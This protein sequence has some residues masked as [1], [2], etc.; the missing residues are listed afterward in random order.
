MFKTIRAFTAILLAAIL[1]A[2][3]TQPASAEVPDNLTFAE[4][5][6]SPLGKELA[7]LETA[8]QQ[9]FQSTAALEVVTTT[10]AEFMEQF[11]EER[12]ELLLGV[13]SASAR[14]FQVTLQ[15]E[16]MS[17]EM[18]MVNGKYFVALPPASEL[19][20]LKNYDAALSR[21]KKTN[22]VWML[23]DD[24]SFEISTPELNKSTIYN[25]MSGLGQIGADTISLKFGALAKSKSPDNAELV[26]YK[27][28]VTTQG[29]QL[30][31]TQTFNSAGEILSQE[32]KLALLGI[33]STTTTT[34]KITTVDKIRIPKTSD[35]VS[36][37]ALKKASHQISA[38]K[39]LS[40]KV[41]ALTSK[42]TAL[43]KS[44]RKTLT[45]KHLVDGAKALKYTVTSIKNGVRLSAK[46][47][48][49][50]GRMCLVAT[51][52]KVVA[53]ACS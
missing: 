6:D 25:A 10:R 22:K 35:M 9:R 13:K 17:E 28:S 4:F 33:S 1:L 12:I 49:F 39:S 38:E 51:K 36:L 47:L 5:Y 3:P 21:L 43:A 50:E 40:S 42:A 20:A 34:Y 14:K 8:N 19:E 24:A 15:G 41:K 30:L 16:T 46:Y 37:A 45:S 44:T 18:G 29:L 31:M 32:M 48:G 23:L 2:V 11:S 27:Y 26:D 7:A 53:T 52:G